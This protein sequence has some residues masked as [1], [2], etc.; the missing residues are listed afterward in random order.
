MKTGFDVLVQRSA[1]SQAEAGELAPIV[2]MLFDA[3]NGNPDIAQRVR[4][5]YRKAA[6]DPNSTSTALA[7]ASVIN[8]L[9]GSGAAPRGETIAPALSSGDGLF[10]GTGAVIGAGI[11]FG[12]G[13]PLGAGV[14][15]VVGAAVGVCIERS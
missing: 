5:F 6:L 8:S 4:A 10:G 15:A 11:G 7:I 13:G 12:F 3:P 9:V 14:G 1:L 2:D